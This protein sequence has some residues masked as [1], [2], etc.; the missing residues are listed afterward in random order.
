MG[1]IEQIYFC[2]NTS[3]PLGSTQGKG[4][5]TGG[6]T[7]VQ[8]NVLTGRPIE[9]MVE[10]EDYG[11]GFCPTCGK[12]GTEG[13][14]NESQGE[15]AVH[16]FHDNASDPYQDLHDQVAGEVADP[17]KP[18]DATT[19]QDRVLDLIDKREADDAGN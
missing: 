16:E 15:D 8:L 17:K 12:Q 1:E 13:Q 4:R 2:T 6:I 7:A 3:C 10:G 14:G 5:F 18:T 11:A 19:A 9:S